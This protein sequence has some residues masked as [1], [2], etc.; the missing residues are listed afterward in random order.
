MTLLNLSAGGGNWF[1]TLLS[2][3]K[4]LIINISVS[5]IVDII[6]LAVLL[7]LAIRFMKKRRAGKLFLGVGL[8]IALVVVSRLIGLYAVGYILSYVLQSG[9]VVLVVIFQPEIRDALER[10]G[11]E[12]LRGWLNFSGNKNNKERE[13]GI[14]AICEAVMDMSRTKTGALIVIERNSQIG[15]TIN[16][17]VEIDAKLSPYLIRNIFFDKSPLHDGA[18]VIQGMRITYAGCLLPLTRRIDIDLD[19]GTRHRAAIGMSEVSDAVIIVVSEETGTVSLA[20]NG[21]FIRE[22]T[23]Q[24]LNAKLTYLLAN[25][26]HDGEDGLTHKESAQKKT[27]VDENGSWGDVK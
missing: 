7:Y 19:L 24:T 11:G 16:S 9:I 3:I 18:M 5:D 17:G 12:P 22:F 25:A 21:E 1:R 8:W 26:H 4:I 14:A 15:D 6:L 2:Y 20:C 13:K 10:M 27:G 23:N